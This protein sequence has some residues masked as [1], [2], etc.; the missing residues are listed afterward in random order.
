[1]IFRSLV[2]LCSGVA[3]LSLLPSPRAA[4]DEFWTHWGDGKAELDGYALTQPRYGAPRA[5]TAVMIFV[6][7]D[8]SDSARVKA[9]PGKHPPSDSRARSQ[10]EH[11]TGWG[12]RK[13]YE[14]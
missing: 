8:F 5:G 14:S 13:R 10:P 3:L 11:K 7:E 6:T 9:D 4:A 2:S 1:M 12:E